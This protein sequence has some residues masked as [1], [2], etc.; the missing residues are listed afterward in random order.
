MGSPDSISSA[1]TLMSRAALDEL[2]RK[3]NAG[4]SASAEAV[5][6]DY[7]PY[8]AC[9]S[10]A[11]SRNVCAPS[12]DSVDIV[13][14]V[15]VDVYERLRDG[16]CRFESPEQLRAFLVKATRH[17]FIDRYRQQR[18]T[19]RRQQTLEDSDA[20][21]IA[22]TGQPRPSETFRAD[23]LWTRMLELCPEQHR[24]LL[25]LK[26]QG[27][28]FAEIAQRTGLHPSS[29]RRLLYDL[30]RRMALSRSSEVA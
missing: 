3:I 2:L 23:E 25:R 21:Q 14:S 7:E 1:T 24:D 12:F 30:A 20:E 15:W 26:R 27:C 13:Q 4:D 9:W 16:Q 17:R 22:E 28:S 11:C 5:F 18:R 29:V 19:V 6:R 8:C 10:A